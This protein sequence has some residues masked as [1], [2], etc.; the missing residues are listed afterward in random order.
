[1]AD[2][3]PSRAPR[4]VVVPVDG[5]DTSIR[6]VP[7]ASRLAAVLDAELVVVSVVSNFRTD[8]P[9][10]MAWL[11][12]ELGAL[13][14]TV[15][16]RIVQADAVATTL[17]EESEG[18][19]VCL[20]TTA[21][22]F[23]GDG[24]RHTVT[25]ELISA[26]TSPVI[27]LGPNCSPDAAIGRIVV[28]IDPTHEQTGLAAWATRLGYEMSLPVEFLHVVPDDA[29]DEDP[30]LGPKI[31]IVERAAGES[32]PERLL[33]ESEGAMLAM[34]SHGRTGFRRLIQGSVGAAV[35]A[36]SPVPV[37]VLG[38]NTAAADR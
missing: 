26:A 7:L 31:R 34:G 23:E 27:V 20:A 36:K 28:A 22:P 9:T 5:T 21:D 17:A 6:A 37:L 33:A 4:A 2:A 16:R 10:R 32:V 24:F 29:P 38:P 3:S 8:A 11:A 1:M 19:L 35:I 18:A 25:D 14:D 15:E 30:D 13:P 12:E